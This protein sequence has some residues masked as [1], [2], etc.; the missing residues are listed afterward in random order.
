MT[1][2]CCQLTL[3]LMTVRLLT[4]RCLVFIRVR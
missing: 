1:L 3:V 2:L 4:Q